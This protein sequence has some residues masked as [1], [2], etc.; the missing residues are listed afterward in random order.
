[1]HGELTR[2]HLPEM[3]KTLH[4]SSFL[5]RSPSRARANR[6]GLGGFRSALDLNIAH[7]ALGFRANKVNMQQAIVEPGPADLDAF[8]QDKRPL[9]LAGRNSAMQI[10]ALRVVDLP[11]AHDELIVLDR[12]SEIIGLKT[13]DR[14]SDPQC[15]FAELL[16]IVGWVAVG[17]CLADSVECPLEMI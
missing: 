13:R 2:R 9:K 3:F 16:D 14:E 5:G 4:V 7:A 12:D 6:C 8:G 10:D 17:R 11:T 15:V 1:E